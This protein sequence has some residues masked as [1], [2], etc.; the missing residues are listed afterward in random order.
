MKSLV[1]CSRR[2]PKMLWSSDP[3]PQSFHTLPA[4]H[5]LVLVRFVN[6]IKRHASSCKRRSVDRYVRTRVRKRLT[7]RAVWP[8]VQPL[9]G[10]SESRLLSS[11]SLLARHAMMTF[12]VD[13]FSAPLTF[14]HPIYL[15]QRSHQA[16]QM[17][18]H[19]WVDVAPSPGCP[20]RSRIASWRPGCEYCPIAEHH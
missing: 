10:S 3:V 14:S 11:V 7:V 2:F 8:A 18:H 6:Y 12:Q 5:Y 16:S 20:P 17:P 9:E 13:L 19:C 1:L 15:G 4:S